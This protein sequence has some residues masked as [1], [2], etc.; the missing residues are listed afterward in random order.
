MKQEEYQTLIE[1]L[2]TN[3][4]IVPNGKLTLEKV[5]PV[6]MVEL[7]CDKEGIEMPQISRL[8]SK[9]FTPQMEHDALCID[10][11]NGAYGRVEE[12]GKETEPLPFEKLFDTVAQHIFGNYA[13]QFRETLIEPLVKA[14]REDGTEPLPIQ[15]FIDSLNPTWIE[16]YPYNDAFLNAVRLLKQGLTERM[17]Q[18]DCNAKFPCAELCSNLEQQIMETRQKMIQSTHNMA[19]FII[20]GRMNDAEIFKAGPQEFKVLR[21]HRSGIPFDEIQNMVKDPVYIGFVWRTKRG[22]TYHPLNNQIPIP[23]GWQQE[24]VPQFV[25]ECR[26]KLVT[27][28]TWEN[29]CEGINEMIQEATQQPSV[30][31]HAEEPGGDE[32]WTENEERE[33]TE[34]NIETP[35]QEEPGLE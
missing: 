31:I 24:T 12:S 2:K 9:K 8:S 14:C 18:L 26:P 10:M 34:N 17:E 25:K 30:Y 35:D 28:A 5:L 7:V 23:E 27:F 15:R 4:L 13:A 6:A 3:Q 1:K 22:F 19:E 20:S 33:D 21:F 29:A 11:G 16:N 32:T